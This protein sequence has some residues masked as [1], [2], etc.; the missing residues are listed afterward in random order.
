MMDRV[1]DDKSEGA[2]F[3]LTVMTRQGVFVTLPARYRTV[4][5]LPCLAA[6]GGKV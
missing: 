5:R 6:W 4:P 3:M 2:S 1:L